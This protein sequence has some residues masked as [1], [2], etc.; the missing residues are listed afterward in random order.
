ML[1]FLAVKAMF[2]KAI[3]KANYRRRDY[4]SIL[5]SPLLHHL[6]FSV[7]RPFI[8]TSCAFV[9]TLLYRMDI[10]VIDAYC[11]VRDFPVFRNRLLALF[12]NPLGYLKR[13]IMILVVILSIS[14][15]ALS[16][17][18]LAA[19]TQITAADKLLVPFFKQ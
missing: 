4:Y 17:R 14:F 10:D 15:I 13:I 19:R 9:V 16:V 11:S 1:L 18:C 8:L 5:L 6:L 12:D 3:N 7:L 2:Y